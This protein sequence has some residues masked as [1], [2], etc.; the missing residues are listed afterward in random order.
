MH[1]IGHR[2]IL[3]KANFRTHTLCRRNPNEMENYVVLF[4]SLFSHK[5]MTI[6]FLIEEQFARSFSWTVEDHKKLTSSYERNCFLESFLRSGK[7]GCPVMLLSISTSLKFKSFL[8]S[9]KIYA[10]STVYLV[11]F[12]IAVT[13]CI[14][15][16]HTQ[17]ILC[18]AFNL[19][20][21]LQIFDKT[22]KMI[23]PKSGPLHCQSTF[24]FI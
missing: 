15:I 24:I 19:F 8:S 20:K 12:L 10:V 23:E 9:L 17:D 6:H 16:T 1:L 14:H 21:K 2:L 5:S 4:H 13:P 7:E 22:N 11:F 18:I 3:Q